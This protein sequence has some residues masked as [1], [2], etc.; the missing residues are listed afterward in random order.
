[1]NVIPNQFRPEVVHLLIG[2]FLEP[3]HVKM[4]QP[5]LVVSQEYD[6]LHL[7]NLNFLCININALSEIRL[8]FVCVLDDKVGL[9]AAIVTIRL[10]SPQI[11]Q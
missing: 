3:V 10:F 4:K 1:M 8:V 11:E 9:E 7:I 6:I 2:L 5:A